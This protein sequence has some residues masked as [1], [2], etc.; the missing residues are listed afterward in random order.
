MS[1]VKK[2]GGFWD[3]FRGK[4]YFVRWEIWYLFK[5]RCQNT[6]IKKEE[7]EDMSKMSFHGPDNIQ[8]YLF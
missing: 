7:T 3:F 1:S 8:L 6:L 2:N 5:N 4:M